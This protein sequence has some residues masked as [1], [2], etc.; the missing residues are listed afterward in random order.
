MAIEDPRAIKF[1]N[2][3]VRPLAESFRALKARVD[4]ALVTWYGGVNALFP[5]DSTA[6]SDGREAE[7]VSRLT[8]ADVNSLAGVLA[9]F[10]SA[11]TR[12][13]WR[14]W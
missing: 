4:A 6:L 2:E 8:G 13:A 14:M 11:Q 1:S 9:T 5:N 12:Q 3:Q 10:Q 7:G